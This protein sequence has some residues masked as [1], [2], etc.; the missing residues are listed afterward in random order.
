[1]SII[2]KTGFRHPLD[3]TNISHKN[4]TILQN[5]FLRMFPRSNADHFRILRA[6][7]GEEIKV[8]QEILTRTRDS[9]LIVRDDRGVAI[10]IHSDIDIVNPP[11]DFLL[12][13]IRNLAIAYEEASRRSQELRDTI[14]NVPLGTPVYYI[15]SS[16][17][18]LSS[19]MYDGHKR[20]D[21]PRLVK[22]GTSKLILY[23]AIER[24]REAIQSEETIAL[25]VLTP[26]E[27]QDDLVN[28]LSD[29]LKVDVIRNDKDSDWEMSLKAPVPL[30]KLY[31]YAFMSNRGFI[32]ATHPSMLLPDSSPNQ[33]I[34]HIESIGKTIAQT[35]RI[36]ERDLFG[37]VVSSAEMREYIAAEEG[38]VGESNIYPIKGANPFVMKSSYSFNRIRP[39]L[40]PVV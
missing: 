3:P 30:H 39:K 27:A 14:L 20:V 1:M 15:H 8:F 10:T 36:R 5:A 21:S 40:N 23:K 24:A 32:R 17:T 22:V 13:I 29:R 38:V 11:D 6:I 16:D 34:R 9:P 28:L 18:S 31:P 4:L 12:A 33:I 19:F 25:N 2:V 26:A 37:D 7:P 35:R